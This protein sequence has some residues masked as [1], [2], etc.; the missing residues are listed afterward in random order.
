MR[1]DRR[2]P[3]PCDDPSGPSL[4]HP[5]RTSRPVGFVLLVTSLASA[6]LALAPAPRAAGAAESKPKPAAH[7][8]DPLDQSQLQGLT[9]RCIGPYRGGRV[10]AVTG[11]V[12]QRNVFYFGG[13]GSG[14][15][16]SVDSGVSWKNVSD[17]QFGTG[18]VGAI[19][20]AASDPNILYVGMG[21]GCIR[22]NASHG[23]GV[24]KS[25]DAGRTWRHVGLADTR[26]IGRIRIHPRDPDLVYV[27]ALGHT[28]A[29]NH[30]RGV[31]RSK[32][33]GAS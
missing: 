5:R 6:A 13:T 3:T 24:Y 1:A 20:V 31:F 2:S 19:A 21:E 23:D 29:P 22:G 28:F 9:W 7:A 14:V 18:S 30:Q 33:G 16:K 11:V 12:G 26:Q 10:T 32:D 4:A 25:E 17:G 15:W 8:T 27:A